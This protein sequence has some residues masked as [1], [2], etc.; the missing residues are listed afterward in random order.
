MPTGQATYLFTAESNH[1]FANMTDDQQRWAR[2]HSILNEHGEKAC[3]FVSMQLIK[4]VQDEDDTAM[5]YWR[6][7]SDRISRLSRTARR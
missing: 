6:S 4:A 1:D 2:A 7:I 3:K 5:D